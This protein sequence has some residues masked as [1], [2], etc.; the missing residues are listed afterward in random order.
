MD[1]ECI[2][3]ALWLLRAV[4]KGLGER[5]SN[6]GVEEVLSRFMAQPVSEDAFTPVTPMRKPA[7][8]Y[9][10]QTVAETAMIDDTLAAGVALLDEHLCWEQTP[11]YSDELLG[12]GFMDDY[13]HCQLVGP[14]GFF[15]GDDFKL[16]LLLLGP[17]R[18]YRDHY[19]P[20]PE[21]YWPLTGPTSWKQG[22]GGFT[23]RQAGE[24]IWHR[25]HVVHATATAE[26]PL[27]AVWCW[28]RDTMTSARLCE[29]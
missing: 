8:R 11:G 22:N 9:L 2:D 25:P 23:T 24:T 15:P 4:A 17:H 3:A 18:H 10:P 28:T 13:A 21:L 27:L 12:E 5:A 20:A 1:R 26:T 29:A 7:C 6:E 19:H 14:S 16:G